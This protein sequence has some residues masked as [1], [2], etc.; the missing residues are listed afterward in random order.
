MTNSIYTPARRRKKTDFNK[1]ATTK[2]GTGGERL[3]I[4]YFTGKG[5]IPMTP[6]HKRKPHVIDTCFIHP[7]TLK[8]FFV[9]A[10]TYPERDC[11]D[12]NGMDHADYLK[13]L[14]LSKTVDVY[15]AWIDEKRRS[16]YWIKIDEGNDVHATKGGDKVYFNLIHTKVLFSLTYS[17]LEK[18]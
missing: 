1:L 14:E 2:K 13:Y 16:C 5:F 9:D 6:H 15:V 7:E 11:C 18:L 8:I 3:V 12:D 17:Q 10:K 4:D